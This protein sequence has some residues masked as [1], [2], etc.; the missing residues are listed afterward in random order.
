MSRLTDRLFELEYDLAKYP[1]DSVSDLENR[2]LILRNAMR[3]WG[4]E[5]YDEGHRDGS[6]DVRDARTLA[7]H[8]ADERDKAETSA[9]LAPLRAKLGT[10]GE[11]QPDG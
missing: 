2:R 6:R 7:Q 1:G 4:D 8:Y 5:R 9:A 11:G 3:Q 10:E